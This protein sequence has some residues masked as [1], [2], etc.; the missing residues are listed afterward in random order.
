MRQRN[1]HLRP[2]YMITAAMLVF[3]A[4][5][6]KVMVP[7]NVD[8]AVFESVALVHF[9]SN[10]EGNLADYARQR[11]LQI[12]TASQPEARIIEVGSQEE[13]LA[14]VGADKMDVRAVKAIGEEYDVDAIITGNLDVSDVRPHV[15]LSLDFTAMGVEADIEASL[16]T[17]LLDTYDG[18]TVWTSSARGRERVAN[19]NVLSGGHFY[20]GADD[21]ADAYGGLVDGLVDDVTYDL[22]VRY[23][24]Q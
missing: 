14:A 21:P 23:E 2:R 12:V 22:R 18:A 19:I 3:L 17:K 4:C 6:P 15:S 8:L 24:R 20:F 1:L 11:F 5:G 9:T 7:P 13:V 10:A 16:T